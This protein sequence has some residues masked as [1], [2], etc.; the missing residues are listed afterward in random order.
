VRRRRRRR[1]WGKRK[2]KIIMP[3]SK[4]PHRLGMHKEVEMEVEN[5]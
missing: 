3:K 5:E 2:W 4:H 1:E